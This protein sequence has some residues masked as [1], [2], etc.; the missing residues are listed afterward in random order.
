[1]TRRPEDAREGKR[2]TAVLRG[3]LSY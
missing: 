1:V 3:K 2:G